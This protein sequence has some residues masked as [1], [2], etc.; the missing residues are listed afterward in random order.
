MSNAITGSTSD[1]PG[2]FNPF[3]TVGDVSTTSLIADA[4]Y[5]MHQGD[6]DRMMH[7]NDPMGMSPGGFGRPRRRD[8][9]RARSIHAMEGGMAR[10]FGHLRG[11]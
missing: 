4:F 2:H 3:D 10:L 9:L 5:R 8:S 11:P 7:G 6:P 1:R